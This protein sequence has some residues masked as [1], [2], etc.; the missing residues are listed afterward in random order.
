M[1]VSVDVKNMDGMLLLPKG[2]ELTD[3]HINILQ[4]WGI[5]EI[6]VESGAGPEGSVDPLAKLTPEELVALTSELKSLFWQ[7]DESNPGYQ[8]VFQAILKRRVLRGARR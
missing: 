6:V 7:P 8:A 5:S 4:A 2:C 1:L 3:R